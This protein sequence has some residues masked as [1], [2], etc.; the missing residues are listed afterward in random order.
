MSDPHP[1]P[2][3]SLFLSYASEDRAVV[4][5][6]RD[7]LEAEGLEVW[8][9]E[10][11]LTGGEAWDRKIR[12]QIRECTYF[13]PIISA[14]SNA[15]PEG[16]FRREWRVAVE[17]TL[18]MADDIIFLLPVV[19]DDT[20]EAG[21]RVPDPFLNVQWLRVPGGEPNPA[22]A[23]L[24]QRLLAGGAHRLHKPAETKPRP[25]RATV[26]PFLPPKPEKERHPPPKWLVPVLELWRWMPR[27]AKIVTI[28]VG[29][30]ILI[31]KCSDND[32]PPERKQAR[33]KP[34][35][36]GASKPTDETSVTAQDIFEVGKQVDEALRR[37]G[38]AQASRRKNADVSLLAF[39]GGSYA[40][41]VYQD[42]FGRLVVTRGVAT[43]YSHQP[44]RGTPGDSTPLERG[45]AD[46]ARL[47]LSAE[48]AK[49]DAG[50]EVLRVRLDRVADG[51]NLWT[52]DFPTAEKSDTT[53]T[54]IYAQILPLL[55][56]KE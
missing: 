51:T 11:E 9:D 45:K 43:R 55:A 44:L 30:P 56:K 37:V 23:E 47:V 12:R 3:P 52:A 41:S 48:V 29:V 40:D 16:Y 18:D 19:I 50:S 22:L 42:L 15:R 7:A 53:A 5:R 4:R 14:Q 31:G 36:R 13:M 35:A 25:A 39:S 49:N 54:L 6:L 28:V 46:G 24:S 8:Y 27:W 34:S 17:R 32:P 26:P 33:E 38:A 20:G 21:A 10:N 2:P 1:S